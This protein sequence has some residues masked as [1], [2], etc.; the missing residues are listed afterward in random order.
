MPE[1]EYSCKK[2]EQVFVIERSMQDFS[3][4]RSDCS[5]SHCGSENV[6]RIWNANFLSARTQQASK[7]DT[8]MCATNPAVSKSCCP[9]D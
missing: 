8:S 6:S 3:S 1:Y 7:S 4:D 5:C 9:C 2:C